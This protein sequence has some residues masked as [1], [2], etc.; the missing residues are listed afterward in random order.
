[1][2]SFHYD[3]TGAEPIVR[4]VPIYAV[5]RIA[6]GEM[7]Q[8]GAT[9][10]TLKAG[11]ITS[12][13]LTTTA[14]VDALGVCMEEI[15]TTS[16][17]DFGDIVSTAATTSTRAIS[18][19]ASTVATGSRYGKAIINPLAI[20]LMR[21]DDSSTGYCTSAAV[22]ASTTYTQTVEQYGEGGWLYSVPGVT[23]A[24]AAN[25]GQLR[26]ITV[27]TST[28]SY[29][30]LTAVTLAATEKLISIK[31][32]NHRILGISGVASTATVSYPT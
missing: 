14:G 5:D 6:K 12:N 25:E 13:A 29:T 27:S 4:D 31:P 26:Y 2:A 17:A 8:M 19:I 32:R 21:W 3:L 11:F 9:G 30:L 28:T 24:V 1:M 20:Y 16:P 7:I 22:S 23:G 10:N 18:S 15:T